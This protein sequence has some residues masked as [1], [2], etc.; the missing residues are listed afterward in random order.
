MAKKPR[1][2]RTFART[3]TKSQEKKLIEN[4][5]QLRRNPLVVIPECTD[6]VSQK[7]FS[8]AI[9]RM[10]KVN[11]FKDD[12]EKLEKYANKK[13]VEAALA[14]TLL[15]AISEKAPYLGVLQFPTG[16]IT[17]AQR[18]KAGKEKLV[19]FQHF[20][21]PVLRVL[22]IK[23]IVYKKKLYVYSWD[24]GF[25]CSGKTPH[26][27]K[28]FIDFITQKLHLEC[29]DYI[30]ICKH[31]DRKKV[32]NKKVSTEHYLRIFW[33]SANLI[34]G[35]CHDCAKT[36]KNTM[37]TLSKYMLI[38][39]LSHDF[40]IDVIAEVIRHSYTN[41]SDKTEY[42]TDYLSGNLTDN[43][44]INKNMKRRKDKITQSDEKILVYNGV[45]YG[46]DVK[47]FVDVLHA[48]SYEKEAL[49]YMLERSDQPLVLTDSTPNKILELFW[50]TYGHDF[51]Q[52]KIDDKKMAESF[53]K[54]DDTPSNILKAVEEYKNRQNILV[55]LPQFSTLPP[56]ASYADMVARTY[57]TFGQKKALIEI[58]K[59]PDTPKGKSISYAFLLALGEEK[60]VKWKYSKE[61]IEYGEYLKSYAQKLLEVQPK[62]YA[63]TLQSLLTA[64][65]SNENI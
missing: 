34:I 49:E 55:Q 48:K 32:K 43:E 13:G 11:S 40:E 9:K 41:D 61:E 56:L 3:A 44:L 25:V 57:R 26:P 31:L 60:D 59:H 51:L 58:K 14:G 2:M 65:G 54:L 35:L 4:A 45:S 53:F 30:C 5:K 12:S 29:K 62:K 36:T 10:Q 46:A 23:D 42:I 28:P 7:Y 16:D 22:G 38:P 1:K 17:F 47:G 8:K 15:L 20:D 39:D 21:N 6:K 24:E 37:F 64:S 18:G 33:K 52:S 19:A 27:P 50:N 63:E